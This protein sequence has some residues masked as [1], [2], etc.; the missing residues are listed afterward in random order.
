MNSVWSRVKQTTVEV[1][2]NSLN[3]PL[4]DTK[5]IMHYGGDVLHAIDKI[6]KEKIEINEELSPLDI[7][8]LNHYYPPIRKFKK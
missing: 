6:T 8:K 2:L 3:N 5:S 4:K 7:E 1:G